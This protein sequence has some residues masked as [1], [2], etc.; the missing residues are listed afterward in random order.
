[1]TLEQ[2]RAIRP[3]WQMLQAESPQPPDIETDFDRYVSV[4][5][6]ESECQPYT[7]LAYKDGAPC[8]LLIGTRG[9]LSINC[10]IGYLKIFRP[11]L[12]GVTVHYRG[13]LGDFSESSCRR[14]LSVLETSIRDNQIDVV[15]FKQLSLHSPLYSQVRE[16]PPRLCRSRFPK[17]DMHWRMNIPDRMESF[18]A[19]H[20]SKTRG[21][22]QR[23][24]RNLEKCHRVQLVEC[25]DLQTLT[26]TLPA[27]AEVSRQT[28][29]NALG[30]GLRNDTAVRLQLQTA[31]Q[32]GWL[33]L[34]M[35]YLDDAPC[36]FQ[37]GFR[38]RGTYFLQQMGFLPEL[39][40][41]HIG[42]VLFLHV[43]ERLCHDSSVNHFDF[44][45][46][47]AEYKRR[48]ATEHWNEA[49]LYMF[50]PRVY[51]ILVNSIHAA[52]GG[53]STGMRWAFQKAGVEGKIK[54]LW[55]RRLQMRPDSDTT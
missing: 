19:Q 52:V 25:T 36:A 49:T 9:P 27:A 1:M 12:R 10:K 23:Y 11:S 33:Y 5:E 44:G 28:Y 45:F 31:A 2:I 26:K 13:Y 29:Q 46:G 30:W 43:V 22:L 37:L 3:L 14:L 8:A 6:S 7:L 48:F 38:Y 34:H 24:V 50:A 4:I 21:T 15:M 32:L 40:K 42:T 55:R 47:D 35:L 18:Y 41:L 17:I 54:Q 51:P 39:K 20:S 16:V 53:L